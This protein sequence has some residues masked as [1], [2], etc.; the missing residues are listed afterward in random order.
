MKL[1]FEIYAN[2]FIKFPSALSWQ[3]KRARSL[4]F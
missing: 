4:Y 3:K 2:I 1:V